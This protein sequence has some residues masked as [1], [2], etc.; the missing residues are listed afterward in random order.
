[1]PPA[2]RAVTAIRPSCFR[3]P[4]MAWL[5]RLFGRMSGFLALMVL[6]EF[7]AFVLYREYGVN[8]LFALPISF[9]LVALAGYDT[10]RRLPLI[11][12]AVFG[13]L[14]AGAD[15]LISWP[16]GSY[17]LDGS[18]RYP[19]EADPLIVGT[20]LLLAAVV[21]AIVAAMAGIVARNRRR[22]RSRRSALGKLAYTAFDEEPE[23]SASLSPQGTPPIADKSDGR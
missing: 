20:S 10:V 13:A 12:G 19:D 8:R 23:F 2:D 1:M 9:S 15:N 16:I 18:F 17:V 5:I 6:V 22:H 11:W 21:G 7:L 4:F 14:L 3:A